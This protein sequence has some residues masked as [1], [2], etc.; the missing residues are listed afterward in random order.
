MDPSHGCPEVARGVGEV[1]SLARCLERDRPPVTHTRQ[2]LLCESDGAVRDAGS[3]ADIRPLGVQAPEEPRH[4]RRPRFAQR[5]LD[6][7]VGI[8]AVVQRA[9]ELEDDRRLA[10]FVEHDR[11]VGLL[12]GEHAG[13]GHPA[14]VD[15]HLR[16]HRDGE[17]GMPGGVDE[18]AAVVAADD[19]LRVERL[20]HQ[21]E[22]H[23]VERRERA[24]VVH[25]QVAC[26]LGDRLRIEDAES[27]RVA[28][29]GVP[30]LLR[31]PGA[32]I[33]SEL[34]TSP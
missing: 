23:V 8:L 12:A 31:H 20:G 27:W 19:G 33:V 11:G 14:D 15:P 30:P 17:R 9:E 21:R 24:R 6:G 25:E 13:A 2:E 5:A 3:A 34:H 16:E 7:D 18:I 32:E 4:V 29:A 28:L 22:G 10:V 1:T 26:G